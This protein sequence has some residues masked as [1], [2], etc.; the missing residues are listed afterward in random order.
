MKF[1]NL[2]FFNKKNFVILS[3]V[4]ML[5][6]IG[7]INY[8]LNKQS[9]LQTS[10]E[11]EH[12]EMR[13]MEESGILREIL[14]EDEYELSD[15]TEDMDMEE[16]DMEENDMT[17]DGDVASNKVEGEMDNAIIVD[18]RDNSVIDVAQETSAK[19][20][21][22]IT[23]K[24]TMKSNIYFIESK[25]ERDKKR[26][27][28]ISYLN[29]I[30]NNQYTSEDLR[31]QASKMKMDVVASTDKELLIE[32]MI[33]AKGFYDAVVY[34]SG[35]SISIV[36]HSEGL[37]DQEVAQIVDIVRRETDISMDNIVIM[38]KK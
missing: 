15:E 20:T 27:E 1:N 26:S 18:S 8:N 10:S 23:S 13:M 38:N 4:M 33:M 21:E 5:G 29:D 28:M 12:Y 2:G 37:T 11:L 7:Y 17:E 30:I 14:G 9:L 35:D 34:L 3:L 6:L 25:L 31:N 22:I 19:I 32:N 24:Q 16:M 36:V